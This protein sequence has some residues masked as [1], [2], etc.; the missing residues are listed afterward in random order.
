[1]C[2]EVECLVV[3][4]N[5][6]LRCH[7]AQILNAILNADAV[8][9]VDLAAR[10]DCRY[11][12]MLLGGCEDEYCVVWWLL[13]CLEEG[14]ERRCGEHMHLVDDEHRVATL[15][16]DDAHLLD[17]VADIIHRVVRR[18]IELVNIERATFVERATR[19]ALVAGLATVGV[20]AVDG[21]GE[22]T[23]TGGLTYTSRTTEEVGVGQLTSLDGILEGRGYVSLSHNRCEGCGAIF[24][25]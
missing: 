7:I 19:L 18:S 16:R 20:E 10:E 9:V 6:L 23:R 14:V 12:L 15:L 24:T 13:K 11:N 22:D 21:L 4:R 8:E 2:D 5:A 17:E 1:M 3:G 25:G